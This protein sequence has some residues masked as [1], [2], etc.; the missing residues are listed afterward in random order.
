MSQRATSGR[1]HCRLRAR[2][3]DSL[4]FFHVPENRRC[5]DIE[6]TADLLAPD[7]NDF[8]LAKR[9]RNNLVIVARLDLGCQLLLLVERLRSSVGI[10]QLLHVGILRP[11]EPT[12][13]G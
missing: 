7:A 2:A 13:F 4:G 3:G 5:R 6:Q 12:A 8:V 10:A 1:P 11:A 9:Y